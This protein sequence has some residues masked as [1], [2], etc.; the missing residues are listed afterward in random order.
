[1][2]MNAKDITK[3]TYDGVHKFRNPVIAIFFYYNNTLEKN[4]LL[5]YW[6]IFT[7]MVDYAI[8]IFRI[9]VEQM[10]RNLYKE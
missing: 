7:L 8:R 3:Y 6:F 9:L 10:V 2:K 5:P 1:M 4:A